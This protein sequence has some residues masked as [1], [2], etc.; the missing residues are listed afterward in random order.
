MQN[1]IRHISQDDP[2][3]WLKEIEYI[4]KVFAKEHGW[5]LSD[6]D[7]VFGYYMYMQ[8]LYEYIDRKESE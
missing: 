4:V 6:V 5:D 3:K 7:D 8:K 1:K 2:K